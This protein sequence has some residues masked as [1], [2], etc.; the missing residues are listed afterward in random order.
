MHRGIVPNLQ[1]ML[2]AYPL[3]SSCPKRFVLATRTAVHPWK[4]G[5]IRKPL[6][7]SLPR[8][9]ASTVRSVVGSEV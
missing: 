6:A 3:L 8:L 4:Y 9:G 2:Q 1:H 5:T 7:M